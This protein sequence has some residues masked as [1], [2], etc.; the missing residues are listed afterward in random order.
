MGRGVRLVLTVG[1]VLGVTGCL[2]PA[3][4]DPATEAGP[5]SD[6]ALDT[7]TAT[8]SIRFVDAAGRRHV[9]DGPAGRI[10]SL[11]PSAT[12]TLRALGASD[13]VVG[14]TDY[15]EGWADSLPSVGGGLEP[16]LE[17]LVALEPDAVIRFEG[18]Q[19]PRTPDRLDELGIRH[20]AVRPVALHDV[21]ETNR[22]IGA[23]VGRQAAADSLSAAIRSGLAELAEAVSDLPRL[24]VVYMLGGS[25]PWVAG[26]DTYIAQILSLVG[27]D[28]AFDDLDA[29][30]QAVS[31]EELRARE[32]D[33]VLVSAIGSFDRALTPGA[34][35]ESIGEAL[36]APGPDVVAEARAVAEVI[37]GRAIR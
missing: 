23:L 30:Y 34:R 5:A 10:V 9:L 3:D 1:A 7:D 2:P 26:P 21:Y 8:A 20:V 36:E 31:P 29:P 15:D 33:L 18:E 37:H 35:I 13:A 24:R 25:P 14:A 28:N 27:G 4:D 17:A 19:D 12:E 22:I 32:I 11:V 6:S 16:N